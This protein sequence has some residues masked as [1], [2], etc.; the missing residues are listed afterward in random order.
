MSKKPQCGKCLGPVTN[1]SSNG[2]YCSETMTL[3]GSRLHKHFIY[4]I[5]LG[6]A[7]TVVLISQMRT[8]S[9]C[10]HLGDWGRFPKEVKYEE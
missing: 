1:G 10:I 2:G 3:S 4:S 7:H 8:L 9:N 6:E 5:Q